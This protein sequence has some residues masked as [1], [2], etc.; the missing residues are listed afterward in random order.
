MIKTN[1]N[2]NTTIRKT[3][4]TARLFDGFWERWIAHGVEKEAVF[5]VRNSL[6]DVENWVNGFLDYAFTH[7]EAAEKASNAQAEYHYR[8]SGLYYNLIHWIYP[9]NSSRKQHWYKKSKELFILADQLSSTKC[10]LETICIDEHRC[11][12]RVRTPKQPKGCI[13]ILNPIDST[14]EELFSYEE[15]F[16]ALGFATVS[17][18]GPGQ[19]ETYTLNGLKGTTKR[20]D[21]FLNELI[22]FSKKTFHDLPIYLFGTSSAGTWSIYGSANRYIDKAVAVSPAFGNGVSLPEYFTERLNYV[23]EDN[24]TILPRL[25]DV[26]DYKGV[27]LFH[28]NKDV[29][30]SDGEVHQLHST[31]PNPKKIVEY[32]QEG[33]CCNHKLVEVRTQSTQWF[34]EDVQQ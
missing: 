9:Q 26:S 6:Q 23:I 13:I 20:W 11:A 24:E 17:F 27:L 1:N 30:V 25:K 22:S 16:I 3:L 18:D 33:H 34:L 2:P 10:S 21:V 31:L 28:G 32:S 5:E 4:M 12:G 15:H 29:M 7:Y 14:K 19:G 8:L